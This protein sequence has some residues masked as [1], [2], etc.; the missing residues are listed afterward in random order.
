MARAVEH[1]LGGPVTAAAGGPATGPDQVAT[2]Y[3][4]ALHCLE[5]MLA[6]GRHGTGGS[7]ADLG[8]L[9]LVLGEG[10]DVGGFVTRTLGPL[11]DYDARRGTELVATLDPYFG[12]GAA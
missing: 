8:F 5:A 9:G 10:R 4:E 3:T 1:A 11:L 2:A 12:H 6:L 7:M